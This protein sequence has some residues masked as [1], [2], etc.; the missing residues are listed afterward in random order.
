MTKRF[1]TFL[2][3]RHMS[4]V[5]TTSLSGLYGIINYFSNLWNSWV[6][7]TL[8]YFCPAERNEKYSLCLPSLLYYLAEDIP[9]W[10]RKGKAYLH[11]MAY[12]LTWLFELWLL[13]HLSDSIGSQSNNKHNPICMSRQTKEGWSKGK[14]DATG[15]MLQKL[16][17]VPQLGWQLVFQGICPSMRPVCSSCGHIISRYKWCSQ[18]FCANWGWRPRRPAINRRCSGFDRFLSYQHLPSLWIAR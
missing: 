13:W 5:P 10:V 2:P 14:W 3:G 6:E 17:K 1:L 7:D 16:W 12:P 11:A 15:E 18:I 8:M 4:D 9:T